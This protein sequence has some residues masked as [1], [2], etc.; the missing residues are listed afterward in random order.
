M[1]IREYFVAANGLEF[2]VREQGPENG[3]AIMFIMG[4]ACQLT[5]WPDALL[6]ALANE[7]FRVICFDNR[8]IGLSA[9]LKTLHTIDTRVAFLKHRLGRRFP[10]SYTLHDMAH[11]TVGIADALGLRRVHL[12]GASMGGMIAQI[13]A[14]K[15]APRVASL[16]LLMTSNNSPRQP[17]PRLSVL[18]HFARF[19][20]VTNSPEEAIGRWVSMWKAIQSPAYP[21]SDAELS[22]MIRSNYERAYHPGGVIRQMHAILATG[23][24]ASLCRHIDAP[25]L[26]MHGKEDPLVP[27]ANA[28]DLSRK[29]AQSV[30]LP[31]EGMGHD[32]PDPLMPYFAELIAENTRHVR[33]NARSTRALPA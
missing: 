11:D 28:K 9:K 12:V 5:N 21:K 17:L 13:I 1:K 20:G 7:G 26:I 2:C 6:S 27:F 14:A 22:E 29:I 4:Y 10:A 18:N 15:Y 19:R 16:T 8:D 23:S 3:Q 25:T 30:Y 33:A 32:L 24:T 31:I